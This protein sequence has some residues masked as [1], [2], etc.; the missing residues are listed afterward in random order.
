MSLP[1]IDLDTFYAFPRSQE[2]SWE[3]QRAADSLANYGALIVK[4]SRVTENESEEFLVRL[5]C[6]SACSNC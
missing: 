3:C 5:A 4:D 1:V 6:F 2:A